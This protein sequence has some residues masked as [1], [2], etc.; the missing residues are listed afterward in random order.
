MDLRPGKIAI[1]ISG[2][3]RTGIKAYPCFKHF[4]KDLNADV[5]FHTW[6]LDNE[7]L[8]TVNNLYEPIGYINQQ[9]FETI[10]MGSFGNMFYS[11]MMA[12]ELKKKYEIKNNFRYDLVI[13]TRFDLIFPDTNIF[14]NNKISPRTIY[15]SGG[16][17]GINHT[18]YEHHG[19]AD[20]IFWGDSES[21]DIATNTFMYYKHTALPKNQL[22][23]SGIQFDPKAIFLSPGNLIY[24]T[25]INQNIHLVKFASWL[26][27]VP[28]RDDVDHLDPFRDYALIRERYRQI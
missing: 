14:A 16:D 6:G 22:L 18:D 10:S 9:P 8:D 26:G 1:C 23:I 17:N 12:N 27:E 4:F 28:W 7:T 25:C 11:I 21:M 13:K 3:L 5:F 20:L 19:I 24:N 2:M 15:S